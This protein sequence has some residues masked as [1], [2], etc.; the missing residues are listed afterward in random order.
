MTLDSSGNLSIGTT[1]GS[2]RLRVS[3]GTTDGYFTPAAGALYVGTLTNHSVIFRTNNTDRMTVDSSGGL[4][5]A[6]GLGVGTSSPYSSSIFFSSSVLPSGAG[7]NA[8]KW[9]NTNGNVT[10]DTSSRLIKENI[11]DS[12]YG[13]AEVMQLQSRRYFRTDDQK[14]EVGFI[15]DEVETIIP[16]LVSTG[17][18]SLLT[19]NEEDTDIVPFNVSYERLTSVLVNAVKELKAELDTV[20][21]ELATLKG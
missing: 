17:P 10:Y 16:E 4:S 19:K 15:A 3:D 6:G 12:P 9:N 7:T 13:L 11:E 20:K 5:I 8:L 21:A 2:Y 1:S 18:K 14:T